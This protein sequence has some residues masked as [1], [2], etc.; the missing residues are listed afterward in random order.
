MIPLIEENKDSPYFL[1]PSFSQKY[2][3]L[4]EQGEIKERVES[5]HPSS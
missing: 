3:L 2:I 4:K 5:P 1:V